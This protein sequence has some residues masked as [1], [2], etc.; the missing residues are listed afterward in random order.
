MKRL[1]LLIIL[2]GLVFPTISFA[3]NQI[4]YRPFDWQKVEKDNYVIYYSKQI[5]EL[6]PAIIHL[7]DSIN[8]VYST[9]IFDMC[10]CETAHRPSSSH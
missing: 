8:T 3:R 2:L 1:L 7:V 6:M 5:E 4:I 9:E 10:F